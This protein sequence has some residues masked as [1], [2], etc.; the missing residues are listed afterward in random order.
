M[1]GSEMSPMAV[2]LA[3]TT[4]V[5]AASNAPTK[6]TPTASPPLNR[7]N[8]SPMVSS[9]CSASFDFSSTV[10]I[11]MKNGTA[12]SVKFDIVPKVRSGSAKSSGMSKTPAA[13]PIS[14]KISAVPPNA[15]ATGYPVKII[16][17]T[18]KNIAGPQKLMAEPP[19]HARY[20]LAH[21]RLLKVRPPA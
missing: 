5:A 4:P 11:K 10:P 19:I 20:D 1:T 15:N 21:S 18:A 7:P 12:R 17:R 14:A 13:D 16:A 6:T 8:R 3:P 9:S 2:T